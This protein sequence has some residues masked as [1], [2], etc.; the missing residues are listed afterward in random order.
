MMGMVVKYL[1]AA[2]DEAE[3]VLGSRFFEGLTWDDLILEA[4]SSDVESD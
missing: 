3:L 2:A 1:H 4:T